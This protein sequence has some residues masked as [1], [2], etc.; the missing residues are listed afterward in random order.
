[1]NVMS[2]VNDWQPPLVLHVLCTLARLLLSL[3]VYDV[4]SQH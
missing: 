3:E 1:M 4:A 2:T